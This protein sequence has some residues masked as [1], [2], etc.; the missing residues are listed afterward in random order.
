MIYLYTIPNEQDS[1]K[2]MG[3]PVHTFLWDSV[4]NYDKDIVIRWGNSAQSYKIIPNKEKNVL[5]RIGELLVPQPDLKKPAEFKH[6]I[7]S[8]K[9]IAL[10]CNKLQALKELSEVVRTP[11]IYEKDIPKDRL[12]VLRPKNHTGGQNFTVQ[13]GPFSL[14]DKDWYGTNFIPTQMEYRVFFCGGSTMRTRLINHNKKRDREKFK[15]RSLY[16]Y[17]SFTKTPENLHKMTLKAAK[18]I[19]LQT[20]CADVL[21]KNG[22]YYFLELNSCPSLDHPRI[23]TFYKNGL[24]NLLRKDFGYK[25][26]KMKKEDINNFWD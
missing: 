12:V 19:G 11:E 18:K 24:K 3:F 7:N 20:G 1:A 21:Y 14:I 4:E 16:G 6:V 25:E 8:S 23:V 2:K 22:R 9:S 26:E 5:V 17:G 13:K 15:C 10:N